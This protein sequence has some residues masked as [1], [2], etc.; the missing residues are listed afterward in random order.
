MNFHDEIPLIEKHEKLND[1]TY[2][3]I[4]PIVENNFLT[5]HSIDLVIKWIKYQ[6]S[7][8]DEHTSS[9]D[10][11]NGKC[12]HY[13]DERIPKEIKYI[14]KKASLGMRK[15]IQINLPQEPKYLYS[16]LPQI[17]RW[18]EGNLLTPHAD[19]IEQ[20][21]ISPNS[22]PWRDFGGVIIL[23]SDFVGGKLYYPN[24]N[25]E[26]TPEKGLVSLHPAG[27]KYTHGVS[28]VREGCRYTISNFFTFDKNYAG[29]YPEDE[30]DSN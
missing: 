12:I 8:F 29:F 4:F 7:M 2:G 9:I 17:V 19:N 10:Y 23:N 3:D 26:V 21:G 1:T 28:Q 16:E 20:D 18:R 27:L 14:L 15:F 13:S 22:S 24:L 11:W 6:E 25:L 30:S 5:E